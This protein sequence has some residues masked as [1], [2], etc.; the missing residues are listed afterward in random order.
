MQVVYE[1][2]K[3]SG[4]HIIVASSDLASGA[5]ATIVPNYFLGDVNILLSYG[6]LQAATTIT[7]TG[8]D[9]NGN[10]IID[11]LTCPINVSAV[12]DRASAKQFS[13]VTEIKN[14]AASLTG[15]SA[16]GIG[17]HYVQSSDVWN[18]VSSI[19]SVINTEGYSGLFVQ[20]KKSPVPPP[21]PPH[22]EYITIVESINLP[23]SSATILGSNL[24]QMYKVLLS[25]DKTDSGQNTIIEIKGLAA[26]DPDTQDLILSTTETIECGSVSADNQ[27]T[28]YKYHT[29]ESIKNVGSYELPN[30]SSKYYDSRIFI[31]PRGPLYAHQKSLI[32]NNTLGFA[33]KLKI[34]NGIGSYHVEIVIK[35]TNDNAEPINETLFLTHDSIVESQYKYKTITSIENIS[36]QDLLDFEVFVG[37]EEMVSLVN[38]TNLS[39]GE[40]SIKNVSFPEQKILLSWG[41]INLGMGTTLEIKGLNNG[42]VISETVECKSKLTSF[43]P[44]VVDQETINEYT[45]I[46]SIR[47][48]GK[49]ILPSFSAR[50]LRTDASYEN[51]EAEKENDP[52]TI[53]VAG[54]SG[55]SVQFTP[56]PIVNFDDSKT[57]EDCT[58]Y[59][60]VG[61]MQKL[62]S[63][64]AYSGSV[65]GPFSKTPSSSVAWLTKVAEEKAGVAYQTNVLVPLS[66]LHVE[67]KALFGKLVVDVFPYKA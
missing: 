10:E 42:Q 38:T 50:A 15:F 22:D 20:S 36:N 48:V 33:E 16:K 46:T 65:T 66:G 2:P 41:S 30:F 26:S 14:G 7:I 24:G 31:T 67:T 49:H 12:V 59:K 1:S 25:F 6:V 51:N 63:L 32:T 28:Q 56:L 19:N 61:T 58:I 62:Y 64:P 11:V 27:Q 60:A 13:Y 35:G 34:L 29:V 40:G 4:A 52:S 55:F 43:A 18:D 17:E 9:S 45:S 37:T 5:T 44:P 39:N 8:Y 23:G 53:N 21:P 54:F 57:F 47:N 3:E